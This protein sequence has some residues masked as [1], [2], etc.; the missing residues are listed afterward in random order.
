M[1][2][3]ALAPMLLVLATLACATTPAPPTFDI[4][5]VETIAAGTLTAA[6]PTQAPPTITLIPLPTFTTIPSATPFPTLPPVGSSPA[7]IKFDPGAVSG[8][9]AGTV[10]FP[11]RPQ[12]VLYAFKNQRM[13]VQITSTGEAANFAISGVYD[14]QPLKRLENEDRTWTGLLPATQDYLITIAVPSGS[15]NYTLTVTI[16]WP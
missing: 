6:A 8:T 9:V 10:V 5:A 11:N 1:K 7:R 3:F 12:Y 4:H 13:T 14:G 2:R 15:V 16:V